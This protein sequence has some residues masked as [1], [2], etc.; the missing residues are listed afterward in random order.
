MT[1][2]SE[3]NLVILFGNEN[4]HNGVLSFRAIERCDAAIDCF[5]R[6]CRVN[7]DVRILPTGGFGAHFINSDRA[8]GFY[9]TKYLEEKGIE[10]ESIL[11]FTNS[12]GTLEDVYCAKKIVED[13]GFDKIYAITSDY[14][15]R[16]VRF[17]LSKIFPYPVDV[18]EA[19]TPKMGYFFLRRSEEKSFDV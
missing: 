15:A 14:H 6:L 3:K 5:N 17:I 12:S 4:Y 16:R 1:Y 7:T 19:F 8:H 10:P 11:P 18:I 9:L 2:D 13:G